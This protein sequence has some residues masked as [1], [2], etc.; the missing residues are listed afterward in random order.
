MKKVLFFIVLLFFSSIIYQELVSIYKNYPKTK[1][2]R[3][4]NYKVY[5]GP[6][7]R[8]L[9]DKMKKYDM[10][11]IEPSYYSKSD[12]KTLKEQGTLVFGYLSTMEVNNWNKRIIKQTIPGD[13][14]Y[15][16]GK[17][18]YFPEWDSYLMN[19]SSH[20]YQ[21]ILLGQLKSSIVNKG[22][23][24]V[25]LDTVGDIDNQQMDKNNHVRQ[26]KGMALFCK[27]IKN[28][29]PYLLTIQNSGF[30]T[31][32]DYTIPYIDGVMW[33]SFS[34]STVSTDAWSLK[35]IKILNQ[36][37]KDFSLV[38]LTVS[39]ENESQSSSFAKKNHFINLYSDRNYSKW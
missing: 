5:Y 14:F 1:F 20:H 23:D 2:E 22:F 36:L 27:S 16:N 39:S 21:K 26:Q 10:V 17:K 35:Q 12:I 25:F 15:K 30:P 24:G 3:I 4:S 18:V 6:P 8:T 37:Q 11:I 19:I 7:T 31:L 13:Y 38:V 9:L 34:V 28:Q 32:K 29:Y 33:E